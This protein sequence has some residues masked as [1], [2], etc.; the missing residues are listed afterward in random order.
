MRDATGGVPCTP[1]KYPP[2]TRASYSTCSDLLTQQNARMALQIADRA[3]TL[4]TG[5]VVASGPA[6][7]LA[8]SDEVHRRYLGVAT[9]APGRAHPWVP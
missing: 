1:M 2:R 3:Y 8:I 9:T 6:S 4:Q 5:C 7:E